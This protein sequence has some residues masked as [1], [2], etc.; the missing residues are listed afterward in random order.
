[1]NRQCG[2]AAIVVVKLARKWQN[3]T[4]ASPWRFALLPGKSRR[5][6]SAVFAQRRALCDSLLACARSRSSCRCSSVR[7]SSACVR[8]S[9]RSRSSSIA[10]SSS[11]TRSSRS[12]FRGCSSRC[13]SSSCVASRGSGLIVALVAC[14]QC[15]SSQQGCYEEGFLHDHVLLWFKGKQQ[16]KIKPVMCSNTDMGRWWRP[17]FWTSVRLPTAWAEIICTFVLTVDKCGVNTLSFS[18][19]ISHVRNSKSRT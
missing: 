6:P 9:S 15:D 5:F 13:R 2:R 7:S 17:L 16:R 12:R 11:G 8:S 3:A 1:M 14:S 10:R 18:Y 4:D 19:K